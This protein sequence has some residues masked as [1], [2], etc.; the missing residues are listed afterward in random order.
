[1]PYRRLCT[2]LTILALAACQ[3][4]PRPFQPEAKGPA[5]NPLLA[6]AA[7]A[8]LFVA[9]VKG[10]AATISDPLSDRV[11][12]ELRERDIPASTRS[13]SR[14]TYIVEGEAAGGT[15]H[16]RLINPNGLTKDVS[17]ALPLPPAASGELFNQAATRSAAAIELLVRGDTRRL[18]EVSGPIVA[19]HGVNG[20][21]GDG[22][23]ALA[24][25]M[26]ASLTRQKVRLGN[27][28]SPD[29]F[30]VVGA[31]H[32]SDGQ[33]PDEQLVEIVWELLRPDGSSLGAVRQQNAI[34][35]GRLDGNWGDTAYAAAEGGAEGLMALVG[36][37]A[38][39]SEA[40]AG[41]D[42]AGG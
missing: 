25:A 10:L 17:E 11:A 38:R 35:R 5:E 24:R 21:P 34:P 39:E 4:L 7:D 33:R 13:A 28:D 30:V 14:G 37:A 19:V 27:M 3:P 32:L 31:V 9:P 22:D 23:T 1:M 36:A 6:P 41:K 26:T 2:V 8:S 29:A 40:A 20:A 42:P 18:T 16:W 12:A 15:L